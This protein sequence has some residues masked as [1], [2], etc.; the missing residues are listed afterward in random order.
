[1]GEQLRRTCVSMGLQKPRVSLEEVK[2]AW[3]LM[4]MIDCTGSVGLSGRCLVRGKPRENKARCSAET[5]VITPV[6]FT[7]RT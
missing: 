6:K 3:P 5:C 4:P 7:Q 1:L 2:H